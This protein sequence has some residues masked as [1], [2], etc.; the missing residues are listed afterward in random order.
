[1][2]LDLMS[3]WNDLLP[4]FIFSI[5][6]ENLITNPSME[7][8]DLLNFC[9]LDWNDACLNSHDNKRIVKT[10]SDVQARNK[11]NNKSINSWINYE[12]YLNK[13]LSKLKN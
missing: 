3:H 1:M 11:M 5:K 12:K 10:A 8:R 9:N 4:E 2:Y 7:I 6:Y 13:S